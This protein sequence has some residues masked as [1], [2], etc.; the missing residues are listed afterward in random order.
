MLNC[1]TMDPTMKIAVFH[2]DETTGVVHECDDARLPNAQKDAVDDGIGEEGQE[3]D[4]SRQQEQDPAAE[5][6][7]GPARSVAAFGLRGRSELAC[8]RRC[9][10]KRVGHQQPLCWDQGS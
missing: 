3:I 9:H 2:T 1:I 10:L 7:A 5:E 4:D 6:S 8:M